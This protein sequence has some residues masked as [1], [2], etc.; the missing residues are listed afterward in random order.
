MKKFLVINFFL[1]TIGSIL[2]LQSC[3][4]DETIKAIITVKLMQDTNIVVPYAHVRMEKFD[5]RVEG[6]CNEKGQ[7]EHTFRDEAILDVR[8]WEVDANGNEIRY[9]TT[10]IRLK[11]GEIARKTVLIN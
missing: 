7:F 6:V 9:G 10:T 2:Y 4:E 3:R 8:A 11:K 1:I 5:V